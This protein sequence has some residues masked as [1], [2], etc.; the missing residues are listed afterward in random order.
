MVLMIVSGRSGSGKSVALRALEDM[1]FYC[2]DNLP[3]VLL[4]DLARTLA[5]REISAAVSIDAAVNS[6]CAVV[7]I[8]NYVSI[9]TCVDCRI[10]AVDNSAAV[11][12]Y[13][14]VCRIYAGCTADIGVTLNINVCTFCIDAGFALKLQLSLGGVDYDI[15]IGCTY[16]SAFF[17]LNLSRILSEYIRAV[18]LQDA[19]HLQLVIILSVTG[20]ALVDYI[21]ARFLVSG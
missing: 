18:F 3:V 10:G 9:C 12:G 11:Q 14:A 6:Q 2:V 19:V 21:A 16:C 7:A 8:N 13:V 1:G 17:N 5:D 20:N 15:F 4:P